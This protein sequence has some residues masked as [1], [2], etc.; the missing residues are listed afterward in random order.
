MGTT[1]AT[2]VLPLVRM[3]LKSQM[4]LK[5]DACY[6]SLSLGNSKLLKLKDQLLEGT[7]Q[8]LLTLCPGCP[9][10]NS[11]QTPLGTSPARS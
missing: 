8:C 1:L 3:K 6:L 4:K 10:N 5:T 7:Y 2:V 11:T 9:C